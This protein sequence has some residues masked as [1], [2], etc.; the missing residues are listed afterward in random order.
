[1]FI[2]TEEIGFL[3]RKALLTGFSLDKVKITKSDQ[4]AEIYPE[5]TLPKFVRLHVHGSAGIDDFGISS[6]NYLVVSNNV[7]HI[8][9]QYPL[10]Y[11]DISM[12]Q[13]L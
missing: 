8:L 13:S 1:M 4:F 10:N 5:K 6:E 3:F 12:Y 11:C 9:R 7:L 2:V